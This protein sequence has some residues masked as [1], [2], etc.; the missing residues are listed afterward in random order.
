MAAPTGVSRRP[1]VLGHHAAPSAR[2]VDRGRVIEQ[3]RGST[4]AAY[5]WAVGLRLSNIAVEFCMTKAPCDVEKAGRSPVDRGKRGIKRSTA[6]DADG[7]PLGILVVPA[8]RTNLYSWL[9]RG[10]LCS[11]RGGARIGN[12]TSRPRLRFGGHPRPPAGS[13]PDS[14]VRK[15]LSLSHIAGAAL[16]RGRRAALPHRL[17]LRANYA[18]VSTAPPRVGLSE[19][20]ARDDGR[21]CCSPDAPA[22]SWVSALLR[23][24][25]RCGRPTCRCYSCAPPRN[26]CGGWRFCGRACRSYSSLGSGA[27]LNLAPEPILRLALGC[28]YSRA[29]P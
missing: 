28:G 27:P 2:R 20:C 25:S 23:C 21:A 22:P 12:S 26:P 29:L 10:R 7:I 16:R 24:S 17:P 4:L 14:H 5:D 18:L 1:V 13:R 19:R 6:V 8:N 11:A 9:R 15:V 3:L